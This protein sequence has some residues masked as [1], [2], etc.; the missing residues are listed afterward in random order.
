MS[1]PSAGSE[2]LPMLV[3][4][5]GARYPDLH[6]S[7]QVLPSPQIP[8]EVAAGRIDAGIARAAQPCPGTRRITL[9][10][11]RR[12]VLVAAPNTMVYIW[13]PS[14][15]LSSTPLTVTVCGVF[16]LTGV[17]VKLVVVVG[18]IVPS[19]GLLLLKGITTFAVGC[20]CRATVNVAGS[21][22]SVVWPEMAETRNP[23]ESL[24]SLVTD[25]SA[26]FLPS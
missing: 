14:S 16:Q 10:R 20:D 8:P 21:P 12:G 22:A 2:T 23:A 9:R 1:S 26:G 3:E 5:I 18:T 7:A 11:E 17:N 13:L 24:S 4:A 6:V 15:T 19:V 25:T